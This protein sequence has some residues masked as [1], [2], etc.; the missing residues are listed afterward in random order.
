[1]LSELPPLN[2]EFARALWEA[3]GLKQPLRVAITRPPQAEPTVQTLEQPFA[4]IG[5]GQGCPVRLESSKVSFRHAYVQAIGGRLYCV[6]LGSRTGTRWPDGARPHGWLAPSESLA[7]GPYELQ[8]TGDRSSGGN[9]EDESAAYNPLERYRQQAGPLPQ[10]DLEFLYDKAPQP[11]WSVSRVLTL[12]G[13]GPQCKLRF[14][15]TAISTV[16]CSLLLTP[17]GLWVIDLLG[18]G[19]T[20]V[21]DRPVQYAPLRHEDELLIGRYRIGIRYLDESFS[22]S[23]GAA[24]EAEA[25]Q[26]D[27]ESAFFEEYSPEAKP[28]EWLGSIFRIEGCGDTLIVI[29]VIDGCSFRY[30]QLQT[31]SNSLRRKFELDEF[32]NLLMDLTHLH[33]FGSELIGVLISLARKVSESGG[34]AALCSASPKM[35][36]VLKNM[37]LHKLWPYFKTREEALRSF[38]A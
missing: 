24:P 17:Q 23:G 15:A 34:R 13:R 22:P 9:P 20:K 14:E 7:V 12:V 4:V 29:P 16:H 25:P 3:T 5:R 10:V 21:N 8:F 1:M 27:M 36:E 38:E 2:D 31:E 28:L 30:A 26:D 35:M 19:G 6:D 18:K 11:T 37:S 32:Q 33:Y